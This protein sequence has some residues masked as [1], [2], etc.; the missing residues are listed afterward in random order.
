MKTRTCL[1]CQKPVQPERVRLLDSTICAECAHKVY[2]KCVA[3]KK[4]LS[5]SPVSDIFS[6]LSA[7]V[8]ATKPALVDSVE[9]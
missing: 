5:K 7:M 8:K 1:N 6:G 2:S 4:I 9:D 3:V